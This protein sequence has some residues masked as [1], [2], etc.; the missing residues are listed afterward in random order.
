MFELFGFV[1]LSSIETP[2]PRWRR[3][4]LVFT[5]LWKQREEESSFGI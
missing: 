3:Q 1:L 4:L 5:V 2:I